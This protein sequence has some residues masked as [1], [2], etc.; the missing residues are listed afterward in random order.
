MFHISSLAHVWA[1]LFHQLSSRRLLPCSWTW[2][3]PRGKSL[4]SEFVVSE[5]GVGEEKDRKGQDFLGN[6]WLRPNSILFS[7][8]RSRELEKRGLCRRSAKDVSFSSYLVRDRLEI[9]NLDTKSNFSDENWEGLGGRKSPK[10]I[11][12]QSF[13]VEI[14]ALCLCSQLHNFEPSPTEMFLTPIKT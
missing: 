1:C 9:G 14:V 11:K 3:C 5:R 4:F 6:N 10:E 12:S 7:I 2:L 13:R 8:F